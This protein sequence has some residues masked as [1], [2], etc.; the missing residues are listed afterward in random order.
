M[1]KLIAI[2]LLGTS[3]MLADAFAQA[4]A[5]RPAQSLI[6][7]GDFETDNDGDKVPD[8]WPAVSDN[9]NYEVE[10]GN[11]CLRLKITE[12]GKNVLVYRSIDLKPEDKAFEFSFRV[13]YADIKPGA[14]PWFDGRVMINLKDAAKKVMKGGPGHPNF[15]GTNNQWQQRSIR[16]TVPEGAKTLEIM[17]TLFQAAS[18][19]LDFDD[20]RLVR[21][22]PS[23]VPAKK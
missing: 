20:L 22:D 21:I 3:F 14:Q 2:A 6:A 1:T 19:T 8:G 11:R 17:P 7:N 18:G 13:R 4:P 23:E 5:A 10:N 16:F 12:P 9:I 15:R